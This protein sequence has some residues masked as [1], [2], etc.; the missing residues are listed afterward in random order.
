MTR[1]Q[2]E[3][4]VGGGRLFV[5][6]QV[7]PHPILFQRKAAHVFRQTLEKLRLV[8]K[9]LAKGFRIPYRGG[10]QPKMR[11]ANRGKCLQ[12]LVRIFLQP[13]G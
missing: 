4:S 13:P 11:K 2:Q 8:D 6:P 3:S 1:Q 7:A 5:A 9:Q 12:A 10:K